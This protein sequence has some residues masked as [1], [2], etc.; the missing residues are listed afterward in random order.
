MVWYFYRRELLGW[1]EWSGWFLNWLATVNIL[2]LLLW[3][4]IIT[5]LKKTCRPPVYYTGSNEPSHARKFEWP[6]NIFN[7]HP[8][9]RKK[10]FHDTIHLGFL[11]YF[12]LDSSSTWLLQYLKG[13]QAWEI[14]W[15]RFWILHYF[16]VNSA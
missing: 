15:L 8:T 9:G 5:I 2:M 12:F 4:F 14:F 13:T 1:K 11:M 10:L 6:D 16:I 7:L 3:D